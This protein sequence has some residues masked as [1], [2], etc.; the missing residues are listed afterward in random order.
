VENAEWSYLDLSK[1][2]DG[3]WKNEPD[4]KQFTTEAGYPGVIHRSNAC[5][6]LCGYIGVPSGH[7][8]HRE[9]EHTIFPDVHGGVFYAEDHLTS[10]KKDDYPDT[11]WLG[12]HCAHYTDHQ[13]L[14]PEQK[15]GTEYRNIAYVVAE[16]EALA[17]QAGEAKESSDEE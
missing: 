12:F 13:P 1:W 11:W 10:V 16:V 6:H 15:P 5:G 2:P 17:K 4:V 3:P 8:W 7:P 9:D 14:T